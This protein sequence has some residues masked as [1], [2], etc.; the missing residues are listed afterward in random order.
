[1]R[2]C[3]CGTATTATVSTCYRGGV[4][5]VVTDPPYGETQLAWDRWPSGWLTDAAAISDALWCFGTMRMLENAAEFAATWKFAQDVVW[6]KQN[7]S[8]MLRDRFRRVHE[9]ATHWYRGAWA[10]IYHA[11]PLTDVDVVARTV[12][13]RSAKGPHLHGARGESAYSTVTGGTKLIRSV[14]RVRSE[15]MRGIHPTQK[16]LGILT[17]LIEY[18]VPR[19]GLVVDLFSG[20]G[21][22]ALAARQSGR[23]CIAFEVREEYAVAAAAR[24]SQQ[25]FDLGGI[26]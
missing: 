22:V 19:G 11:E 24:L 6:E 23:R 17:P 7:G 3:S 9:T 18:S 25:A 26:A 20:S 13:K 2:S 8:G 4:H 1:M 14:M 16:P 5:A 21:S 10:D 15:H 12:R